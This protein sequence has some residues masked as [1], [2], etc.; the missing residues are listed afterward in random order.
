MTSLTA[1]WDRKERETTVQDPRPL[2]VNETVQA[3]MELID[4][5]LIHKYPK[6]DLQFLDPIYHNQ[7]YCLHSFIPTEGAQPD[8][9]GVYGFIKCRG[10]FPNEIEADQRAEYIIRNVDSI[11]PIQTSWVGRPTPLV[12]GNFIKDVREI[13]IQQKAVETISK[14][15][16]KRVLKEKQER[17][18][19]AEREKYLL[20]MDENTEEDPFDVY[21]KN[22]VKRANL[23]MTYLASLEKLQKEIIN[24]IRHVTEMIDKTDREHA[25]YQEEF[26][27]RYYNALQSSGLRPNKDL[28]YFLIHTLDVPDVEIFDVSQEPE[29]KFY[30]DENN[31]LSLRDYTN[32]DDMNRD[33]KDEKN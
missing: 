7:I 17:N 16:K 23:Y 9:Q 26:A 19:I 8:S 13:D 27:E 18:E 11:H 28:L 22:R 6:R 20:E 15:I 29:V 33:E 1:P 24:P 14:D 21:L 30:R 25:E 12:A 3:K 10:T 2:T 32:Q 4:N 5:H 31:K